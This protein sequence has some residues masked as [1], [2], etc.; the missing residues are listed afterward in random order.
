MGKKVTILVEGCERALGILRIVPP[1]SKRRIGPF[2]TEKNF[3]L[4]YLEWKI[5]VEFQCFYF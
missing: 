5:E 3:W 4:R 1:Q 2:S